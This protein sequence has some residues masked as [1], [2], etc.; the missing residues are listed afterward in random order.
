M[1]LVPADL[2]HD[3]SRAC[4]REDPDH[5]KRIELEAEREEQARKSSHR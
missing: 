1:A 5:D 3:L 2:H 4:E